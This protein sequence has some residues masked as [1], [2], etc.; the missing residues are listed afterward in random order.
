MF[1]P[2]S[3]GGNITVSR[4]LF[5]QAHKLVKYDNMPEKKQK[6]ENLEQLVKQ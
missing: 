2:P 5:L 4:V 6:W 1:P 3:P